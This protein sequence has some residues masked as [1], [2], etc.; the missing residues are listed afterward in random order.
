LW[1]VNKIFL[2]PESGRITHLRLSPLLESCGA[3][4]RWELQPKSLQHECH[5]SKRDVIV[6]DDLT[7]GLVKRVEIRLRPLFCPRYP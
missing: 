2:P 1:A 7:A 4:N 6:F 3:G 5:P